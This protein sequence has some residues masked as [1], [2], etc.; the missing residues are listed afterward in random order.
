[1]KP[2][3][4]I[5]PIVFLALAGAGVA[6]LVKTKPK[7]PE[8]T[9]EEKIWQVAAQAARPDR[10]APELTLYGQVDSPRLSTLTSAVAA[11]VRVVHVSEGEY[12]QA[13]Q[14]LIELDDNDARLAMAQREA[15]LAQFDAD[16]DNLR[17]QYDH[18]VASLPNE[19]QLLSIR[20]RA[21]KRARDLAKSNVGAQSALDDALVGQQQQLLSVKQRENAINQ[22]AAQMARLEAGRLK[23]QAALESARLDLLR[24]RIA[25]PFAGQVTTVQVAVGDRVRTGDALLEL[26]DHDALRVRAQIPN[27]HVGR[28][29]DALRLA[30]GQGLKAMAHVDGRDVSLRLARLAGRVSAGGSIEGLLDVTGGAKGLSLGRFVTLRL[31]LPSLGNV[32]ALPVEGLYGSDRIYTIADNRLVRHQVRIEGETHDEGDS[33]LLLVS[34]PDIEPGTPILVTQLPNAIPGLRVEQ[35]DAAFAGTTGDGATQR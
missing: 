25:A 13:D 6:A 15:E 32:I 22:F 11:D 24:T 31:E 29:R 30:G 2:A 35:V 33:A 5:L 16:I 14:T 9:P 19:K 20:T 8:V 12:V 10:Y 27:R 4:I 34:A 3:K 23:T 28:I 26:F 17:V 18:D 7:Q 21:V 1:M